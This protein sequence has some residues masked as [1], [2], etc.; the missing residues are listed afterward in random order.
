MGVKRSLKTLL[1]LEPEGR[2]RLPE[3][4]LA[5]SRTASARSP[6]SARTAPRPSRGEATRARVTPEFFAQHSIAEL[7]KQSE[8]WLGEQGRITHP[9][10]LRRGSQH[11]EPIA[12]PDAFALIARRAERARVA[13]RGDRSTPRAATSNEAAFLYGLFVRQFGTNNLPDCSNMCHESSGLGLTETIGIG[14][15][16]VKLDDFDHAD[17][18]FIIG[19]NPGTYHPRMLTE[20]QKAARNGC[21]IVSVNPLPETGMIRFK[22][23]QNPLDLLGKGTPIACLFLPVRINGDVALLKGI[24]KEMLETD[25]ARGG[26]VFD[27]DFI[28][29]QHRGLRDVRRAICDATSW[30][31]IVDGERRLA[32]ADPPR[33][34]R[35]PRESERMIACWAM[36]ITQHGN[37]VANVQT[38]RRTSACCAGRSAARGAGV[39]PVRGHSNVQGDRTVGIW[40]KMS[41]QLPRRAGQGIQLLAAAEARLRHRHG[42]QAMH[43]GKVKVFIGLGGNFL[44]AD[45]RHRIHRRGVRAARG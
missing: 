28:A 15:A 19:Q 45:A 22:N 34:R 20:L 41:D 30:D 44:S 21:K 33:R 4:R 18:I 35:S 43:E 32:R 24:M 6:S 8:L 31:E 13:R 40:E 14:K 16:T 1:T 37:G 26:K 38:H 9:M 11:Y 5:R 7:L 36:G 27:H 2:L 17:S 42:L 29:Q 3:L 10:V 12:W 23:P 39:C 25:G